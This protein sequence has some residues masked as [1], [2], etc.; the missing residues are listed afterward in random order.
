MW[1]RRFKH[2]W[3]FGTSTPFCWCKFSWFFVFLVPALCFKMDPG[4]MWLYRSGGQA[5]LFWSPMSPMCSVLQCSRARYLILSPVFLQKSLFQGHPCRT[6]R[7]GNLCM[8]FSVKART[9]KRQYFWSLHVWPAS[10][11]W[12]WII[13]YWYPIIIFV[14]EFASNAKGNHSLLFSTCTTRVMFNVEVFDLW[15]GYSVC[16]PV[17]RET[18]GRL[19]EKRCNVFK[20]V[21]SHIKLK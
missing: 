18:R 16:S 14:A 1:P 17:R 2:N 8:H 6:C 20:T 5:C 7:S 21:T 3:S 15:T 9:I 13:K 11:R 4:S 12:R 10:F 19:T